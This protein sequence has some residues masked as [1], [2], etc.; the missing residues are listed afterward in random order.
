MGGEDYDRWGTAL[1]ASPDHTSLLWTRVQS[2]S[3]F[4]LLQRQK[5]SN[6]SGLPLQFNNPPNTSSFITIEKMK[7]RQ[8]FPD[9]MVSDNGS[10]EFQRLAPECCSYSGF[11]G[12][13]TQNILTG[14]Q[15][16]I[17]VKTALSLLT[18]LDYRNTPSQHLGTSPAQTFLNTRTR[19][20]LDTTWHTPNRY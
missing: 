2:R 17:A 14:L 10:Q 8:G 9:V 12:M 11:V 16:E 18:I 1:S 4:V 13:W 5:P 3:G 20:L 6:I 7:T 19:I 15:S